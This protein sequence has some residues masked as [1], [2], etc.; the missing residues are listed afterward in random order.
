MI[1][2][3]HWTISNLIGGI[4]GNELTVELTDECVR[5]YHFPRTF[6]IGPNHGQRKIMTITQMYV[7]FVDRTML[8][9][10]FLLAANEKHSKLQQ[11]QKL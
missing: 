11:Y 3:L 8:A 10:H 5:R 7:V 2:T 6:V 4:E 1:W 9:A